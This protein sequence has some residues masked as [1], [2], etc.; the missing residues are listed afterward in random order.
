MA[1][2]ETFP[3]TPRLEPER[4]LNLG[5]GAAASAPLWATFFAVA[6]AGAAYWWMTA[7]T[8]KAAVAPKPV[9][10]K[11]FAPV[12]APL[13][14]AEPVAL[15]EAE[16]VVAETVEAL[17][18]ATV[19]LAAEPEAVEMT[20]APEAAPLAVEPPVITLETVAAEPVVAPAPRTA[21]RKSSPKA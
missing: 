16:P 1:L 3:I 13:A 19:E 11:S 21:R 8:R 7:W 9:E 20:A 10:T 2:Q 6:S 5:V 18:A 4:A 15:V 12:E 14:V 17:A